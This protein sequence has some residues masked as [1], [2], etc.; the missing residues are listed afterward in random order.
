MKKVKEIY[1][2]DDNFTEAIP[3]STDLDT[4]DISETLQTILDAKGIE[5]NNAEEV[6]ANIVT[7]LGIVAENSEYKWEEITTPSS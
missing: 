6:L 7:K 2:P 1:L 3:I 4:V 5:G